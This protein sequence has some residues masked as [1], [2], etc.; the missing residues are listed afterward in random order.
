MLVGF[1]D[2]TRLI[3]KVSSSMPTAVDDGGGVNLGGSKAGVDEKQ[4]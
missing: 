2:A 3:T 1:P 4:I